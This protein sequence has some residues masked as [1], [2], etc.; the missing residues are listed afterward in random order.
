MKRDIIE[1]LGV[2]AIATTLI[3]CGVSHNA[4]KMTKRS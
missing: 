2:L 3:G 1:L 4:W